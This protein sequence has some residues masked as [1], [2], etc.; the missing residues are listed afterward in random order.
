M[1]FFRFPDDSP[2]TL[3]GGVKREVVVDKGE[4]QRL[5]SQTWLIFRQA[6]IEPYII[7]GR[8]RSLPLRVFAGMTA[9]VKVSV[10][11]LR[12]DR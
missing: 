7:G 6:I 1:E 10:I 3:A 5:V 11:K 4:W 9:A 12:K 8:M 2:P